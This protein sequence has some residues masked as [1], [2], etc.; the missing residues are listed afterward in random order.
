MQ[1]KY[2]WVGGIRARISIQCAT[3]VRHSTDTLCA[4]A[5]RRPLSQVSYR[6][7]QT[8][9]V[10]TQLLFPC[11]GGVGARP[12]SP[13]VRL[14][15]SIQLSQTVSPGGDSRSESFGVLPLQRIS[16]RWKLRGAWSHAHKYQ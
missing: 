11:G 3:V 13:G 5:T 15:L 12:K 16:S 9:A 7:G 4:S 1:R 6:R 10:H 2:S 8:R 14:V